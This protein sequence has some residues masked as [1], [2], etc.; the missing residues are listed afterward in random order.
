[1]TISR[2]IFQAVRKMIAP[3]STRVVNMVARSIVSLV[4]DGANLQLLQL[5]V[6]QTDPD[7][8]AREVIEDA[9]HF[10]PYGFYAVPK[11]G[12]E[13]VVIFR[14]GDRGHPLVLAVADRRVR[15]TGGQAGEVGLY[16][17]EGDAVRLGRGHVII[18]TTSGEIRLGSA[19]ATLPV[20]LYRDLASLKAIFNGWTPVA[21]DGGA[22]LKTKLADWH[23]AGATKVKAE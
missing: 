20:A 11:V 17:D 21:N 12:A 13:A 7:G 5:S 3:L 10:Q 6:L 23:P 19:A 1:M 22:A 4:N 14:N 2:D 9:E 8:S 16:T 15:P 18:V